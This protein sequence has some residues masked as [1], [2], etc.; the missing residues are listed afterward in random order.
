MD[1]LASSQFQIKGEIIE[2]CIKTLINEK[3]RNMFWN[4]NKHG[5]GIDGGN[6]T[7][8]QRPAGHYI[9]QVDVSDLVERQ[10]SLNV[11]LFKLGWTIVFKCY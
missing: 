11:K 2:I 5:G 7:V 8:G 4:C 6:A 10:L 9:Y 1:K 3:K